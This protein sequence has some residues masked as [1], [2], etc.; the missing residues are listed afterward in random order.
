MRHTPWLNLSVPI[1][2]AAP[3]ASLDPFGS[4]RAPA[5]EEL[6]LASAAK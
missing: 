6:S 2:P 1:P 3:T 5:A 4:R